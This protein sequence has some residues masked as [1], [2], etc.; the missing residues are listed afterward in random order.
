MNQMKRNEKIFFS[1]FSLFLLFVVYYIKVGFIYNRMFDSECHNVLGGIR[2]HYLKLL[3]FSNILLNNF[4]KSVVGCVFGWLGYLYSYFIAGLFSVFNIPLSINNLNY[5]VTV[6]TVIVMFT[7]LFL[8]SRPIKNYYSL[9]ATFV[10]FIVSNFYIYEFGIKPNYI[11]LFIFLMVL[12]YYSIYRYIENPNTINSII[13]S[14]MIFILSGSEFFLSFPLF[15]VILMIYYL[16]YYK[17]KRKVVMNLIYYLMIWIPALL[18][19]LIN[20]YIY[21]RLSESNLGLFGFAFGAKSYPTGTSL[22]DLVSKYFKNF[23]Q[24]LYGF[25]NWL[26]VSLFIVCSVITIIQFVRHKNNLFF[27]IIVLFVFYNIAGYSLVDGHTIEHMI[28]VPMF[29]IIGYGINYLIKSINI[30][31]ISFSIS[32]I[33]LIVSSVILFQNYS[34]IK[35]RKNQSFYRKV[36]NAAELKTAGYYIREHGKKHWSVYNLFNS[37]TYLYYSEYFYGRL[38][39]NGTRFGH[40]NLTTMLRNN[41]AKPNSPEKYEKKIGS[42]IDFFVVIDKLFSDEGAEI[43][44]EYKNKNYKK[45]ADLYVLNQKKGSIYSFHDLPYEKIEYKS[46]DK[47]WDKKYANIENLFYDNWCGMVSEWGCY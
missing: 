12:F 31:K 36:P 32:I 28:F 16:I 39:I 11:T 20:L 33:A 7:F 18:G 19:F 5:S 46:I 25:E 8:L 43:L 24:I 27:L 6:F 35:E 40:P 1:I 4:V 9:F 38:A 15:F 10:L 2:L 29:L 45:V 23:Y 44:E 26:F 14:I 17:E 3:P 41:F 37:T 22:I 21:K 13:L 30:K 47:K 42:S 34:D